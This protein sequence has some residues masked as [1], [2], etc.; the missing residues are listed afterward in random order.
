[1]PD[2][3]QSERRVQDEQAMEAALDAAWEANEFR[4]LSYT[5][6]ELIRVAVKAALASLRGPSTG[7][8]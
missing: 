6:E 3:G 5:V 7:G 1:M 4:E 2:L 8:R